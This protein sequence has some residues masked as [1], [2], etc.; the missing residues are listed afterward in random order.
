MAID[1]SVLPDWDD[2]AAAPYLATAAG[3]VL[4]VE[5]CNACDRLRWPPRP[6]CPH[7]RSLARSPAPVSG[8][9]T[10]WSFTIVHAPTLPAFH[11]LLPM[12]VLIV[13]LDDGAGLRLAGRLAVDVRDAPLHVGM[14]L[15]VDFER[16]DDQRALPVWRPA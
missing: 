13:E 1:Q 10:L 11:N 12:A 8:D 16:R 14:R 15:R 6:H 5:R 3:G 4:S 7:C 9:G 2:D